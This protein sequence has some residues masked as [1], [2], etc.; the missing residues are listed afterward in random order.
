MERRRSD[1][2]Q[3]LKPV[4][5]LNVTDWFNE[6]EAGLFLLEDESLVRLCLMSVAAVNVRHLLR[7]EPAR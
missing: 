3:S 5:L 2:N 7:I 1:E 4:G 6:V